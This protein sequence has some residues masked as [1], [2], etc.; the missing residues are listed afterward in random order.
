MTGDPIPSSIA[1]LSYRVHRMV[2][3][4]TFAMLLFLVC[5]GASGR[6][7]IAVLGGPVDRGVEWVQDQRMYGLGNA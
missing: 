6:G 2:T 5:M 1:P 7:P 4:A 3:V